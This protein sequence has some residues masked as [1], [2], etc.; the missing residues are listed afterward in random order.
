MIGDSDGEFCPRIEGNR[1]AGFADS[2]I[3]PGR[4]SF[5]MLHSDILRD[6]DSLSLPLV[7]HHARSL[8]HSLHTHAHDAT[9]GTRPPYTDPQRLHQ[10][11]RRSE[12]RKCRFCTRCSGTLYGRGIPGWRCGQAVSEGDMQGVGDWCWWIGMRDLAEP[13]AQW[14][15]RLS[16]LLLSLISC[17]QW[18]SMTFMSLIW[19]RSTFPT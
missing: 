14:V 3:F 5:I 11:S 19:T 13:G 15:F 16:G 18:D 17:L 8:R 12:I 7:I 4:I 9:G 10:A 2:S 1:R 6:V